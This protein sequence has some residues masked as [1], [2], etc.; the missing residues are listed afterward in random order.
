MD[1]I[2]M[3]QLQAILR[4]N[5]AKELLDHLQKKGGAQFQKASAAAKEGNEQMTKE[6]LTPLMKD[7]KVEALLRKLQKQ[8][9]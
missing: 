4:T 6:L 3:S 5:E 2:S 7:E 8:I 9:E 1:Q